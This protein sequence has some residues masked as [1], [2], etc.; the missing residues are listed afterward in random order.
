MLA[1]KNGNVKESAV[2]FLLEVYYWKQVYA[3]SQVLGSNS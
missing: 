3:R 1:I 2:L